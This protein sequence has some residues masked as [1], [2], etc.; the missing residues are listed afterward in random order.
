[1]NYLPHSTTIYLD[2]PQDEKLRKI[3]FDMKLNKDSLVNFWLSKEVDNKNPV[4]VH[5][6]HN[7]SN[8]FFLLEDIKSQI[9]RNLFFSE[10]NVPFH[11]FAFAYLKKP[12]D[13]TFEFLKSP[14]HIAAFQK[15]IH[16]FEDTTDIRKWP[17]VAFRNLRNIPDPQRKKSNKKIYVL[18]ERTSNWDGRGGERIHSIYTSLKLA[19]E[20]LKDLQR[21]KEIHNYYGY[22]IDSY[23]ENGG[24]KKCCIDIK[25]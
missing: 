9:K 6:N 24:M 5:K 22:H 21:G 13:D 3:S 2:K 25:K 15:V 10:K 23:E 12:I 4:L 16:H 11:D 7:Y 1:M 18:I 8:S 20:Q 19:Q 14:L 17:N